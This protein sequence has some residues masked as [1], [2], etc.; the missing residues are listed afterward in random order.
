MM[1]TIESKKLLVTACAFFLC[2]LA[3][4]ANKID[5]LL[6]LVRQSSSR[7]D[8]ATAQLHLDL[9]TQY[10][11]L[12][13]YDSCIHFYDSAVKI[14]QLCGAKALMAKGYKGLGAAKVL[15]GD[16]IGA[17]QSYLTAIESGKGIMPVDFIGTCYANLAEILMETGETPE[18]M[19]ELLNLVAEAEKLGE[20]GHIYFIYNKLG[21]LHFRI[22]NFGKSLDYYLKARKYLTSFTATDI[23]YKRA[24]FNSL[25]SIGAAYGELGNNDST[26]LYLNQALEVAKINKNPSDIAYALMN[27]GELFY[28]TEQPEKALKA[29]EESL[30]LFKELNNERSMGVMLHL[31]GKIFLHLLNSPQNALKPLEAASEMLRTKGLGN[32]YI[33]LSKDLARTY[34][35][36]GYHVKAGIVRDSIIAM[37]DR[38]YEETK[39]KATLDLEAKY[40]SQKKELQIANH[41]VELLQKE[42]QLRKLYIIGG[43]ITILLLIGILWA[44][45]ARYRLQKDMNQALQAIA[46]QIKTAGDLAAARHSNRDAQEELAAISSE[47]E[48]FLKR[49]N[50]KLNPATQK[51]MQAIMA[52]IGNL[53]SLLENLPTEELLESHKAEKDKAIEN[54][55]SF[56]YSVSHDLRA[57]LIKVKNFVELLQD[58]A[59]TNASPE[60]R[61]YLAV[62]SKSVGQM[63]KMIGGLLQYAKMENLKPQM[64]P[65]DVGELV[66]DVFDSLPIAEQGNAPKLE[67]G[68]LPTVQTDEVLLRQVFANLLSNAVKFVNGKAPVIKVAATQGTPPGMTTFSIED[69]GIGFDPEDAEL[70]FNLFHRLPGSNSYEGTGAGLAIVKKVVERL[71]G[72]A[73]ATSR[74]GE[75]AT[76]YFS[77]P[78]DVQ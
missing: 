20:K 71:G 11:M 8:S 77:L 59:D 14:A 43:I 74:K 31:R 1:K 25:C 70:I 26:Q 64:E 34:S 16:R 40:E 2:L 5:S 60:M 62:I 72:N 67:I 10:Y 75:G 33:E 22:G 29:T 28:E 38:F 65:V 19:K 18:A 35:A 4:R 41:Q 46:G 58:K 24:N 13:K 7:T 56:N 52:G 54:L 39:L 61:D 50:E 47:G 23:F 12:T 27:L 21:L 15:T 53:R 49:F 30:K 6:T 36:L 66:Q 3:A 73:W 37:S 57:P 9:G 44:V 45:S 69:N 51:E 55:K 63:E 32:D 76:L 17:K 48:D 78:T 68:E 42:V